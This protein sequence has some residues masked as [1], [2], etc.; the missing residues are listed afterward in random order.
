[1][2]LIAV[3]VGC[4]SWLPAG[5]QLA[6][7]AYL[8]LCLA[9][10]FRLK[11]MPVVDVLILAIV[12]D[13]RLAAGASAA[14]VVLPNTLLLA[15]TC[16]FLTMAV[17]KRMTQLSASNDLLGRLS[18]RPYRRDNLPALRLLAGATGAASVLTFAILL[19]DLGTHAARPGILW[20][21]LPLLM[22][23]LGRCFFLAD[24]GKLNEDL[25]LFVITDLHSSIALSALALLLIAA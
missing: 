19:H 6:L 4:A 25:V 24:R 11:R 18:G 9:Y 8:F 16:F 22:T 10:S 15:C 17:L 13:L 23:W 20:L 2:V 1:M 14:M 21:A 5:F 3:A 12:Y 7:A